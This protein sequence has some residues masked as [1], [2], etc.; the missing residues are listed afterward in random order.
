MSIWKLTYERKRYMKAGNLGYLGEF[1]RYDT[2]SVIRQF[3][4]FTR[5]CGRFSRN[6]PMKSK[7]YS[8]LFRVI[9]PAARALYGILQPNKRWAPM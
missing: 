5:H 7:H 2:I 8:L 3:P 9:W 6:T 1:R 4:A